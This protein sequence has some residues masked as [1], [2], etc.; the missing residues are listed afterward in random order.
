MCKCN[1]TIK[2]Q[3]RMSSSLDSSLALQVARLDALFGSSMDGGLVGW[4]RP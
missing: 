3:I 4:E 1:E 2:A